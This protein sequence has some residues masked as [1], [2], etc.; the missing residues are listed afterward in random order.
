MESQETRSFFAPE[1]IHNIIAEKHLGVGSHFV[2]KRVQNGKNGTMKL[3][4]SIP[5]KASEAQSAASGDNLKELLLQSIRDAVDIVKEAGVQFSN[6][7][8][9]KLATTLFIQRAR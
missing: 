8:L 2:L 9:Q 1:E 7:E 6:D 4:L 3:E 5:G